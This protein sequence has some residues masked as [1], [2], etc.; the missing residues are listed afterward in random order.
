[1]T[2]RP[3]NDNHRATPPVVT[4]LRRSK[5]FKT[6]DSVRKWMGYDG[7]PVTAA[8][9]NI[10]PDGFQVECY[11]EAMSAEDLIAAYEAGTYHTGM[12]EE[13]FRRPRGHKTATPV[14]EHEDVQGE[15]TRYLDREELHRTLGDSAVVLDMACDGHT[16]REI[17]E[18]LGFEGSA[19]TKERA[20]KRAV[21]EA[22]KLFWEIAA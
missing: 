7:E 15:M 19:D 1:M 2:G 18:Y 12:H 20:G 22:A 16:Y 21:K 11:M 9:D 13:K 8:N 10:L 6:L 17:G 4:S 14:A 5:D 3:A